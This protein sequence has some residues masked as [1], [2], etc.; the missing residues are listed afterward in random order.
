MENII[1]Q[2][3]LNF[4][5]HLANLPVQSLAGEVFQIQEFQ[6][7][8]MMKECEEH[9]AKLNFHVNRHASKWHW[10]REVRKYI[11][12]VNKECL[13][14]DMKRYKKLSYDTCARESFERKSYFFDLNLEQ[15]RDKFRIVN[16]MVDTVRGNFPSKYKNKS[17][18]CQSCKNV[19][20][21]P[22]ISK[23]DTQAHLSEVCPVI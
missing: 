7:I 16:Q 12:H 17:L 8:G 10:K 13:L 2:R 19:V 20:Y 14:E 15:V 11:S 18:E 4:I 1:L 22:M 3:K 6:G 21:D 23:R 9:L 5:H